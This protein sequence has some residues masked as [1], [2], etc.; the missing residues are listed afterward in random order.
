MSDMLSF[1]LP[2]SFIEGYADK[3]PNWGF[4]IGAGDSLAELIYVDKYSALK[5][6]GTKEQWHETV[7]RCVEGYYSILKDHCRRNR[8]PWNDFKALSS[9]KDAYDRMWNFK[10]LPP[11][12]GL[13]HMGRPIVHEE[14][15]S[16]ALQNCSFLSTSKLSSHSAEEATLPFTRMM[17]QSMWGVGVGY[18]LKGEGNLTLHEPNPDKTEVFVVPDNREGWAE[19]VG[20]LLESYFFKNR[21]TVKFDYSEVRPAGAALKRFGGRAS[22]PGPLITLHDSLRSQLDKRS[23]ETITSRDILDIMNKIGK[24]VV[25]GG[26]RRSAQ[27]CFGD[28]DDTDYVNAKNWNLPEN[29]ERTDPNTGWAWNSNNSVFV[30]EGDDYSA[31][32]EGI[33]TNGEP[34]F[35]WLDLARSHGR[36][37]DAR[38]DKDWRVAG[39][40]PCVSSDTW[41]MT[42]DG[43]RQVIDL[44][45]N[46]VDLVYHGKGYVSSGFWKTGTKQLYRLSFSDGRYVRVTEDHKILTVGDS[47]NF[48]WIP[49][50]ELDLGA[51]VALHNHKSF[52]WDG[53]GSFDDGYVT[54]LFMGDGSFQGNSRATLCV[55]DQ[56]SGAE[57]CKVE[58]ERIVRDLGV[59]PAFKG[60]GGPFG[61]GWNRLSTNA[62][63]DLVNEWGFVKGSKHITPHLEK[64]ASSGF[65]R[66]FLR[67]LFDADGSVQGTQIKGVS[68]R[69]GQAN[70]E[71]VQAVQ[72]MLARLGINSTIYSRQVERTAMLPDGRGGM[73]E[74]EC[75]ATWDVVIS[76]DNLQKFAERVG[77]THS[78][79]SMKLSKLLDNYK[80]K[81]NSDTFTTHLISIEEDGIEDVYDVTVDTMHAFDA[82][83]VV[84]HNCLEQSLED[85]ELC[86]LVEVFPSKH[87]DYEDFR[88]S[89]KHAYLY[90]KAVTLLPTK[91]ADS[92][93]VMARNRRIGCSISGLAE[94]VETKGWA[95]LRRWADE[96]YGFIEHR[97]E[98]YS[99]WLAVRESIKKTSIKPSGTVSLVAGVTP[100]VHWPTASGSYI[101]RVRYSVNS[102]LV[103]HLR[104]AGYDIEPAQGDPENTVVATFITKGPD[105]RD[106]RSVTI[107]EKAELAAMMQRW[108]ADNQVS[109]TI[110]FLP[111]EREQLLP[112]L[113]SK[114]GQFKGVSFLPL[115]DEETYPQQPYEKLDLTEKEIEKKMK[116]YKSLG[117]LYAVG[118][119]AGGDKF[120]DTDSCSI[121]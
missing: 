117:N 81:P 68:V 16:S 57:S 107:W 18:D 5:E 45:D 79:K 40:N 9:A 33:L 46:P 44:I 22:G 71:D 87:S 50:G 75:K 106:E 114:D 66:G 15:H 28:P 43:P 102:P 23:G 67:G 60:W 83:G 84:V 65:C 8:T 96:G 93:E 56:D 111:E 72:R 95:E 92:N 76:K 37:V 101:R 80:R 69:L 32:V 82:N 52:T 49:A 85:K 116:S 97:D 21:A 61:N 77:F 119:E 42:V 19:S 121:L 70:L 115:G 100:G 109:A 94:F 62:L 88:E 98:K 1:H 12:R 73:A 34:G 24:A 35:M 17:E 105:V 14:G 6:D 25:A 7:R 58:A 64:N 112:L 104:K 108:W 20:K 10:W 91:W 11:G 27:I 59:G 63:T 53:K 78:E 89:L 113:A 36:L 47:S 55:W 30:E 118:V 90:G 3:N 2:D 29:A 74:Y 39:G 99:E 86:T 110:T 4:P 38:N 13:Q 103:E 54:G 51:E 26:A 41:V 48:E 31:M 120:C